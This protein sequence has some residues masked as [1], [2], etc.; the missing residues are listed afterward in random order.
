MMEAV[1]ANPIPIL[2]LHLRRRAA[3]A[4]CQPADVHADTQAFTRQLIAKFG[5]VYINMCLETDNDLMYT[6]EPDTFEVTGIRPFEDTY[7]DDAAVPQRQRQKRYC[8]TFGSLARHA[9]AQADYYAVELDQLRF[10]PMYMR[11]HINQV[12]RHRGEL[13]PDIN[14]AAPSLSTLLQTPRF[15]S[16]LCRVTIH[17]ILAHLGTWQITHE[18]LVELQEIDERMKDRERSDLQRIEDNLRRARLM[19]YVERLLIMEIE[20]AEKRVR[21]AL[22][23]HPAIKATWMRQKNYPDF[24]GARLALRPGKEAEV[25]LNFH[26]HRTDIDSAI[27]R[28]R[29]KHIAKKYYDWAPLTC[30]LDLSEVLDANPSV[31]STLDPFLAEQLTQLKELMDFEE[32]LGFPG[33]V[34]V[35][36]W[37]DEDTRFREFCEAISASL[38]RESLSRKI[39]RD[40]VVAFDRKHGVDLKNYVGYY[41]GGPS[42]NIEPEIQIPH[43]FGRS[44]SPKPAE[45][46]PYREVSSVSWS[47]IDDQVRPP[48]G[49]RCK[50]KTRGPQARTDP[51]SDVP[52][53]PPKPL[54]FPVFHLSKSSFEVFE[55]IFAP[56]QKGHLDFAEYAQKLDLVMIRV[57]LDVE[58]RFIQIHSN[59]TSRCAITSL[60]EA[61]R[62]STDAV[63]V[64]FA[65]VYGI[66]YFG[67]LISRFMDDDFSPWP[68]QDHLVKIQREQF[69]DCT[70]SSY[71][72]PD[73]EPTEDLCTSLCNLSARLAR[74]FDIPLDGRMGIMPIWNEKGEEVLALSVGDNDYGVVEREKIEELADAY[75]GGEMPGWYLQSGTWKWRRSRPNGATYQVEDIIAAEKEFTRQLIAKF[76]KVY[77]GMR[78]EHRNELMYTVEPD[79]FE[80]TDIRPFEGNHNTQNRE[81]SVTY[82]PPKRYC[83]TLG[84]LARIAA[85]QADFYAIELDQLRFE[86]M[87]LRE[88]IE[89][90]AQRR[91]ELLPD[92]NGTAPALETLLQNARFIGQLCRFTIHNVLVHLGTWQIIHEYLVELQEIEERIKEEVGSHMQR[93]RDNLRRSELMEYVKRLLLWEIQST[94]KRVRLALHIHPATKAN[95]MRV[96]D[97]PDFRGAILAARPEK[98]DDLLENFR[99]QRP[100]IDKTVVRFLARN[101]AEEYFEW[102]PHECRLD[103]FDTLGTEPSFWSKLDPFLAEQLTQL[104]ELM[105]FEEMLPFPEDITVPTLAEEDEDIRYKEFAD[106]IIA[107]EQTFRQINL[108]KHI[109]GIESLERE[110]LSRKMWR[111]IVVAFDRKHGVDLKNYVGYHQDEP[112]WNTEADF[113]APRKSGRPPSLN[114]LKSNPIERS[115]VYRGLSQMTAI[116]VATDSESDADTLPLAHQPR[117]LPVFRLSKT[118]FEVFEMIFGPGQKGSLEFSKYAKAMVEVGFAVNLGKAGCRVTF[119]PNPLQSNK[120]LCNH[121][122]HGD[123]KDL[124]RWR[125]RQLRKSLRNAY[126]WTREWFGLKSET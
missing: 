75:F 10:E 101:V 69:P 30:L 81:D 21:M 37:E 88:C 116:S 106:A 12:A 31:W 35:P 46:K 44:P 77:I 57:V 39:W 17:N 80:V 5:K 126:G 55:M 47:S 119:Y 95:W 23:R 109:K 14:G 66:Q 117:D 120:S 16:Q 73:S 22:H 89:Q 26:E 7:P 9:A 33:D 121:K 64:N 76:G 40:I 123:R 56:G 115:P 25:L 60:M 32:M 36:A 59:P 51:D 100:D 45:I 1:K 125:L 93:I 3:T 65:K 19:E 11:E 83:Y 105:D 91:G 52:Q 48:L 99:D 71:E 85:A 62:I 78:L 38:E 42:W 87:Y 98:E 8:Y 54:K 67:M 107:S 4:T 58:L 79:T 110:T 68:N 15:I 113:E 112:S 111:D 72:D 6:V 124:D 63:S 74:Q 41:Q 24:R 84:G 90:V 82:R 114:Q 27:V 43:R 103:L 20:S 92:I 94:E 118:S 104:K 96:E 2:P 18:F 50:I 49:G 108:E 70:D 53:P 28:F 34:L 29:A 13:F 102:T 97:H 122:P 61:E 86:P